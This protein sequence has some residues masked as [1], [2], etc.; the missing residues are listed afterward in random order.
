MNVPAPTFIDATDPAT[1][2]PGLE[3]AVVAIGNFDG[4]HRGHRGV[5]AR[6]RA[7]ARRLGKPCAVLTF[8]PHP[9]D[10]FAKT[11]VIFRLTPHEAKAAFLQKLGLDGLI[12]LTFDAALA[13]LSAQQFVDEVLVR[14]LGVSAVVAG[15]DFHF[16]AKR[17]GT[18]EFLKAEGARLGFIVEI[19]ERISQ[20]EEGSLEAVSSTATRE[21]LTR[22]DVAQAARLLG[23]A[24][25]VEGEVL[26]GRKVGR[27]IGFPTANI[28]LDPS[29][30]LMHGIYAVT[31]SVDGEAYGGAANFGRRPTFDNGPPLL[32]VHVLDFEADLYGKMVEVAFIGFI[33]PETK[34]ESVEALVA[35]MREDVAEARRMLASR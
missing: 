2:P 20:D 24:W 35:R 28:A 33:R 31:L 29:C 6:A 27:T 9:A 17:Q 21:A 19:V 15:Y 1:P 34:F 11:G 18:P 3:G 12:T 25:F 5:I 23:H 8:E 7:L 22:G 13:G 4:L 26:H 16:G 10:F 32:E 14:R 30:K